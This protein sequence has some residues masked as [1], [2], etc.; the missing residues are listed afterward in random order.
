MSDKI[1]N[2]YIKYM[3][4][5]K[6]SEEFLSRLTDTLGGEK[7]AKRRTV[8]RF[9]KAVSAAACAAIVCGIS[10]LIFLNGGGTD[11]P[12]DSSPD[13]SAVENK[14]VE[15]S[16][17]LIKTAPLKIAYWYGEEED[18]LP[19]ALARKMETSLDYLSVSD[20][21][22]FLDCAPADEE[23][24]KELTDMLLRAREC[25]GEVSGEKLYCMA[26]FTDGTVAKFYVSGGKYIEIS[27][28]EKI[29]EISAE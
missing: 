8:P 20:E 19:Q 23:T 24:E 13:T 10:A 11:I 21:N 9:I 4:A 15:R 5:Q 2:D 29:Y 1:K 16:A 7:R 27:G 28:N 26:V 14:A 12:K 17:G 6:P 3:E 18:D 25:E 22:Y